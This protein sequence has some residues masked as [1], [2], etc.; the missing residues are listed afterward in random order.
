MLV[1]VNLVVLEVCVARIAV[2]VVD[3]VDCGR[4][5]GAF[6]I[7]VFSVTFG[8]EIAIVVCAVAMVDAIVKDVSVVDENVVDA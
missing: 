7:L 6:V 3:V 5:V 2:V 1:V 4:E 8:V